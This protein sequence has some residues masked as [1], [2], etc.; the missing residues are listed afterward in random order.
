M[1][2]NGRQGWADIIPLNAAHI[3]VR[4]R[5]EGRVAQNRAGDSADAAGRNLVTGE[6]LA[7][8]WIADGRGHAREIAATPRVRRDRDR[9][10][11]GVVVSGP[12]VISEEEQLVPDERAT[13]GA[14]EDVLPTVR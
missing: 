5:I 4:E 9:L 2:S 3:P 12:L 6:Y 10:E 13:E 11:A 14:T 8:R 7:S 1:G